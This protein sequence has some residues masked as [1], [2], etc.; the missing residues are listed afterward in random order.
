[1]RGDL[2]YVLL[3]IAYPL[4]VTASLLLWPDVALWVF[5][6]GIPVAGAI[7]IAD[8]LKARREPE[9]E[10]ARVSWM[11]LLLVLTTFAWPYTVIRA[12]SRWRSPR[13]S[14]HPPNPPAPND[15]V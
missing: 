11:R 13:T 9:T 5:I 6:A 12:L 15:V 1:M 8:V 7:C 2:S 4:G 14:P 10:R 3:M